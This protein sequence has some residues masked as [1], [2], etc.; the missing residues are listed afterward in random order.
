[1]HLTRCRVSPSTDDTLERDKRG[2]RGKAG[3]ID[4]RGKGE[5]E[6]EEEREREKEKR[7]NENERNGFII[8]FFFKKHKNL[9]MLK[10]NYL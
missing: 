8:V 9:K 6:R 1:L 4:K 10:R 2:K 3:K 7:E 5:S